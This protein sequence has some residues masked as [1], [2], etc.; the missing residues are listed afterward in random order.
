MSHAKWHCKERAGVMKSD[1][2]TF[3]VVRGL[4]QTKGN[5]RSRRPWIKR[6]RGLIVNPL[7]SSPSFVAFWPE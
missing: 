2:E 4:V 3:K 1:L 7:A 6:G 5:C